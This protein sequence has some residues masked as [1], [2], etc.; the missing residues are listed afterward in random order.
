MQVC[1]RVLSSRARGRGWSGARR[2]AAAASRGAPVPAVATGLGGARTGAVQFT[3]RKRRREPAQYQQQG[4]AD[5]RRVQIVDA[6]LDL[7]E[8][9]GPAD[10]ETRRYT[11]RQRIGVCGNLPVGSGRYDLRRST[12]VGHS[13]QVYRTTR[14]SYGRQSAAWLRR[15]IF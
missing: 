3:G 8:P 10:S 9:N 13:V 14:S 1:D 7:N 6:L 12:V 15:C 5:Q 4:A 2:M 11:K